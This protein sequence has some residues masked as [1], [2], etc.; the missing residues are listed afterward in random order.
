M[1]KI[2]TLNDQFRTTFTG[3]RVVMTAAF[4]HLPEVTK[5]KALDAVRTFSA[6][7]RDN[8]P[9]HE[10]DLGTFDIDGERFMFKID[11]HD[12]TMEFGSEDPSDPAVTTRVLTIMLA[13]DY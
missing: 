6:F 2:A 7:T 1:N 8:D 12:K 9:Y 11:Y 5:A 4:Y 3:G 10:H 13:S